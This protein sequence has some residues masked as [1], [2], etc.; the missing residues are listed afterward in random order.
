M[1]DAG[2]RPVPG[3]T[4]ELTVPVGLDSPLGPERIRTVTRGDGQFELAR[5]PAGNFVVGINTQRG[6]EGALPDPRVFYPGVPTLTGARRIAVAAGERVDLADFVLPASVKYVAIS[7]LVTDAGG[8]PTAA[9]RVYL[10]GPVEAD[11]I[12]SEPVET[13]GSG[14]FVLAAIEGRDYRVFAERP[15]DDSAAGRIDSSEQVTFTS[16][17]DLRPIKLTLRRRY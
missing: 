15:R 17:A 16:A 8:V 13:D 7:G 2:G 9:A 14:R 11:Y 6:R 5:V 10:K 3:S 12:L 4:I 1:V